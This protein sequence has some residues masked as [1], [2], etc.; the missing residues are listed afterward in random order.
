MKNNDEVN[1]IK[2][3]GVDEK[4]ALDSWLEHI[5]NLSRLEY[6]ESSKDPPT[7][8]Q[9]ILREEKRFEKTSSY[10]QGRAMYREIDTGRYW[11]VDNLHCGKAA[12]LEVFNKAGHHLGEADLKGKIDK[13]KKDKDKT[14][15]S[16]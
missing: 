5:L 16:M 3:D 12:H 2:L 11:Y 6:D 7:D 1:C 9:T 4:E 8:E 14:I 15:N 13:S 10:Y